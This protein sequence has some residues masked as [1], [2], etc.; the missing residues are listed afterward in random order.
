MGHVMDQAELELRNRTY[1]MFVDLG[2][3]P[4][5]DE[6]AEAI[7]APAADVSSGW[8]RLQDQHA[9]VVD[10]ETGELRM[11]SPFSAIPTGH[12]VRAAGRTWFANCAWDAFGICAA[13]H[14]D[15][16]IG[17]TCPDCGEAIVVHVRDRSPIEPDSVIHVLVPA[18]GW[19][20]DIVFT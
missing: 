10:G 15:G 18:A 19:W 20:D 8:R 11:A 17:T 14:A 6:V 2:R 13:L 12:T 1:A 9:L 3:A 5:R 7:G 4:S 16:T